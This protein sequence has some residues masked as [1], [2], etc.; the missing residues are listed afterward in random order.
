MAIY[1]FE[2]EEQLK[3]EKQEYDEL[4]NNEKERTPKTSEIQTNCVQ[5]KL[6]GNNELEN[7]LR[8]PTE[9]NNP[10]EIEKEIEDTELK[11]LDWLYTYA[12]FPEIPLGVQW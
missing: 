9:S 7:A 4:R 10:K 1:A 2:K 6:Y 8:D 3:I 11:T 5:Q 12:P